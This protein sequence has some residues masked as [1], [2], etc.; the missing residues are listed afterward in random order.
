VSL[1][2]L[3]LPAAPVELLGGDAR[4]V[5][6][7]ARAPRI[8]IQNRSKKSIRYIELGCLSEDAQGRETAAGVLPAELALAPGARGSVRKENTLRFARPAN[9]ITV[10]PAVVEFADGELWVPP[11]EALRDPRLPASGETARLAGLYRR[12]G[13]AAVVQALHAMR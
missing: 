11:A 9:A 7:E 10:Y 8:E 4:V 1:A 13:L 2:F 12:K 5:G 3:H 6:V